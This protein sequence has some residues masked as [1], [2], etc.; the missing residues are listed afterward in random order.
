MFSHFGFFVVVDDIIIGLVVDVFGLVV[1]G[2]DGV[3]SVRADDVGKVLLV[4]S[5]SLFK[6]K[7]LC[8]FLGNKSQWIFLGHLNPYVFICWRQS[9][10]TCLQTER[11]GTNILSESSH[12]GAYTEH[13]KNLNIDEHPISTSGQN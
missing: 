2:L 12:T 11:H 7:E 4:K 13:R 8:F 10:L 6:H 3:L 9:F 5:D 1:F